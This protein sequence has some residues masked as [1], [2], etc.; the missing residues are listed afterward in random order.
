MNSVDRAIHH[1]FGLT[2]TGCRV[3]EGVGG[4]GEGVCVCVCVSMGEVGVE[5]CGGG[6]SEVGGG[7]CLRPPGFLPP[8]FALSL[9]LPSFV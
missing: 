1:V 5:R 2:V 8:L 4:V 9:L 3:E 7:W 6:Q